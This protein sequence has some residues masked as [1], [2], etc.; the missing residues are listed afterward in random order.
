MRSA[1]DVTPGGYFVRIVVRDAEG[2]KM[3]AINGAVEIP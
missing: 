2:Q 3:A 1:F